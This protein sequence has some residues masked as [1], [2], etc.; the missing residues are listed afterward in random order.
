VQRQVEQLQVKQSPRL[1]IRPFEPRHKSDRLVLSSEQAQ[2][3][4]GT[5]H[6][7]GT[8][9]LP[10]IWTTDSTKYR[11]NI[12]NIEVNNKYC[13]SFETGRYQEGV[14]V[15]QR[16]T[17]VGSIHGYS[18]VGSISWWVGLGWVKKKW[19]HVHLCGYRTY[20][21]V[22]TC[23]NLYPYCLNSAC[24]SPFLLDIK[25]KFLF[26]IN[27]AHTADIIKKWFHYTKKRL[28]TMF[29]YH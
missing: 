18:W 1:R 14:T 7:G 4:P 23:S 28:K 16:W 25:Q 9:S 13:Y 27:I 10:E 21:N 3:P 20:Y 6:S 22:V 5:E 11:W 15:T 26:S 29:Q 17:W 19:T 12:S 2:V 8:T 24:Y